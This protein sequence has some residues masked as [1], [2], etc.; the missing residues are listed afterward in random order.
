M[1][2]P[3]SKTPVSKCIALGKYAA[4]MLGMFS[5]NAVLTSIAATLTAATNGLDAAQTAYAG[6]VL[7]LIA[8]RVGVKYNDYVSDLAVRALQ[9]QAEVT[10]GKKAGKV[11]SF[12]FPEGVTPVIRPVGKS[13]IT[14]MVALE[15]LLDAVAPIWPPAADEKAKIVAR[16]TAYDAA[17]TQRETA[18]VASAALRA[19]RDMAKED[20]L[21]VYAAAAAK[22]KAEFPRDRE[23]QDLFFDKVT[24]AV[25]ADEE[26]AT[27]DASTG[28]PAQPA[29][30]PAVPS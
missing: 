4:T 11:A 19:K 1:Q 8:V 15:G 27:D 16:R 22:V 6:S 24:D 18:M 10:D 23:K 2:L 5:D 20:F 28:T 25:V 9:R 3:T 13:Q 29:T 7:S 21:D 14:Q 26:D 17:I 12:L 30:T